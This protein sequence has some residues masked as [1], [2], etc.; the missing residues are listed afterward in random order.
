MFD[1]CASLDPALRIDFFD[2]Y[3]P[4]KP[5]LPG[6]GH[7]PPP[8][9][10]PR[11]RTKDSRGKSARLTNLSFH[12]VIL[13]LYSAQCN[14]PA[15]EALAFV[16]LGATKIGHVVKISFYVKVKEEKASSTMRL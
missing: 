13:Y 6:S 14:H 1:G 3:P 9:V 2:V 16:S 7:P 10:A 4:K 15:S 11:D 8:L 12:Y 5:L